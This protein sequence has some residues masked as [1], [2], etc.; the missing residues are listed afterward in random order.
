MFRDIHPS[1]RLFWEG[2]CTP[3]SWHDLRRRMYDTQLVYISEG[4]V[5]LELEERLYAMTQGTLALI[6]P[7]YAHKSWIEEGGAAVRHCIHFDWTVERRKEPVPVEAYM[8]EKFDDK[9]VHT[10]PGEVALYLPLVLTPEEVAPLIPT[11]EHFLA[12]ARAESVVADMLLWPILQFA[13]QRAKGKLD[14]PLATSR[15]G[16]MVATLRQYLVTHCQE[17][18]GYD[19]FT[20]LTGLSKS[21]MCTAFKAMIGCPPTDYLTKIRMQHAAELLRSDCNMNIS[22]VGVA[23]G[24]P[25]ANYFSRVFRKHF[26]ISP[27]CFRMRHLTTK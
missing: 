26:G 13:L 1:I 6:P 9:L 18:V 15:T 21:Y 14:V 22:E 19:D 20:L 12:E 3:E 24:I 5:R 4:T 8:D 23:V 16:C 2:R 10:V 25:D 11:L 17:P 7:R 27:R